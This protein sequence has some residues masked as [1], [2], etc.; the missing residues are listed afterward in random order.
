MFLMKIKNLY[1]KSSTKIFMFICRQATDE[2]CVIATSCPNTII[3]WWF[4]IANISSNRRFY[5]IMLFILIKIRFL[6]DLNTLFKLG[7][8]LVTN[9]DKQHYS[10]WKKCHWLHKNS[11]ITSVVKEISTIIWSLNM[12]LVRSYFDLMQLLL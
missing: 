1:Q 7:T 12:N 10:E 6:Q 5:R 4:T 9:K 11:D 2:A 3:F 8:K